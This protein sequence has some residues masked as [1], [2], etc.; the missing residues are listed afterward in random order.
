[1]PGG[2]SGVLTLTNL[3]LNQRGAYWAVASNEA[4]AATSYAASL[5]I[6]Y[7]VSN[8]APVHEVTNFGLSITAESNRAYWLEY[9]TSLV[10]SLWITLPRITNINGPVILRDQM[11]TNTLRMYRIGS[12]TAP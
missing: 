12:D 3:G 1:M 11:A 8:T 6:E 10:D 5:T 7:L 4:G 2:L 9:K